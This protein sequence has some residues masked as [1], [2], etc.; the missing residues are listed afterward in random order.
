[1][2]KSEACSQPEPRAHWLLCTECFGVTA[3]RTPKLARRVC[4]YFIQAFQDAPASPALLSVCMPLQK[5]LMYR[6]NRQDWSYKRL[7]PTVIGIRVEVADL[8]LF[9]VL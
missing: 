2:Y 5:A 7:G 3:H 9:I 4:T 6:V 1:M 8:A